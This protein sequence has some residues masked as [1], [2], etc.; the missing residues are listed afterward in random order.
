MDIISRVIEAPTAAVMADES[1]DQSVSDQLDQLSSARTLV[2]GD[3][4]YYPRIL[5]G[6]LPIIGSH[7]RVELQ[8]WGADFIAE[9]FA[10]PVLSAD[11]KSELSQHVLPTLKAMLEKQ[12]Q[13]N[14]VVQSAVQAAAS[15]YPIVF[16]HM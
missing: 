5:K 15:L 6:I 16:R 10:S 12:D 14:A 13:D 1:S 11:V 7:A 2:L 3:A 8:R 4:A 9:T